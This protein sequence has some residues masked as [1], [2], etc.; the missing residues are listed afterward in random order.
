MPRSWEPKSLFA[1]LAALLLLVSCSTP[2]APA[3][4][5]IAVT[6]SDA[7]LLVGDRVN[8]TTTVQVVAGASTAVTW[9]SSAPSVAAVDG[10]GEVV[11]LQ[12]GTAVITATS[13]FD[14][15]KHA[16]V[17]VNVAHPLAGRTVLYYV[18]RVAKDDDGDSVDFVASALDAASVAHG[19][20]VTAVG[21]FTDFLSE[22][23]EEPDLVVVMIQGVDPSPSEAAVLVDYVHAGG[24]LAFATWDDEEPAE[25][26]FEALGVGLSGHSNLVGMAITDPGLAAAFG[27]PV[28]TLTDIG[29]WGVFSQGLT[30]LAGTTSLASF[31]D[32]GPGVSAVVLGNDGRTA[33]IGFLADTLLDSGGDAE[34]FYEAL[35]S[36][37]MYNLARN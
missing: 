7:D 9:A 20:Q 24:Y 13:T 22:L 37:L 19:L 30:P 10:N 5:D 28:A 23:A 34:A 32:G 6:I 15:S 16:G 36:K 33:A 1:I 12:P 8:A 26:I 35:F 3:V 18:D 17:T 21:D 31:A 2:V 4:I 14:T 27:A 11:A 29:R 25:Q